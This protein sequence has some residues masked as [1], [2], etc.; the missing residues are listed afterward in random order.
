M[1]DAATQIAQ[2]GHRAATAA[3]YAS[4]AYWA[5]SDRR[6]EYLRARAV[7]ALGGAAAAIGMKLAPI[8]EAAQ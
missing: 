2:L 4:A 1:T 7:E 6:Q 3:E 5:E 8:E